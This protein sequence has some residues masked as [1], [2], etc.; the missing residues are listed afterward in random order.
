MNFKQNLK[1]I[2]KFPNYTVSSDGLVYNKDGH[3]LN[4]Y[5]NRDGYQMVKLYN[6]GYEKTCT[7]H[8]LVAKAFIP[9]LENKRTVNHI[10]GNKKNNNASNLEWNTYSEN[11]RHAYNNGFKKS[12]LTN[13]DRKNGAHISGEQSRKS[14]KIVETGEVFNSIHECA[15]KTGCDT[16]AI[17]KCCNG[18]AT[19]HHGYHFVFAD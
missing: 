14:V 12:Y 16:G 2:D 18:I 3:K 7:V 9:N 11:N 5:T 1:P 13:V 10:D 4:Q 15:D 6:K 19:K 17:S 8:R